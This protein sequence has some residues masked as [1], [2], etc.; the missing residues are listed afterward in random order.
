MEL[1]EL[2]VNVLLDDDELNRLR[3]IMERNE[4]RLKLNSNDESDVKKMCSALLKM[5]IYTESGKIRKGEP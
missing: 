2:T 3:E 1:H 5:A 4:D